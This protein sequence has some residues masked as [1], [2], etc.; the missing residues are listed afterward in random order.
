MK[1]NNL[2]LLHDQ[3]TAGRV[4]YENVERKFQV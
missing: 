3:M 2:M 1:W 4:V